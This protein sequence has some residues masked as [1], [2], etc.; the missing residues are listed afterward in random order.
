MGTG[1]CLQCRVIGV[2][3]FGGIA[4]YALY[5]RQFKTPASDKGQRLFLAA[6]AIGAGSIAVLRAVS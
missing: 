5:L 3:T 4:S 2:G 1:D 6:F